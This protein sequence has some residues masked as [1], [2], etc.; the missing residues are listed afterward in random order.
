[1]SLS[2][3]FDIQTPPDF[4]RGVHLTLS[5]FDQFQDEN[6]K[7]KMVYCPAY[8]P[9]GISVDS[10][11]AFFSPVKTTETASGRNQ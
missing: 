2:N 5:E 1:M 8:Y 9:V 11:Q 10:F 3:L 6:Y 4:L 7:P